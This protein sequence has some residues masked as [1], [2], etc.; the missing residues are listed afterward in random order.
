MTRVMWAFVALSV[1]TVPASAE[2]RYDRKLEQAA[3]RI[4][5]GKMGDIRGGFTYKQK[6]QLVI[7]QDTLSPDTGPSQKPDSA[8]SPSIVAPTD[9]PNS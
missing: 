9:R 3:M 8:T 2:H 4:V 7:A 1:V 6:L 5:A